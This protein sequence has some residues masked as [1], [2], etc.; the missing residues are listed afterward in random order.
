[1]NKIG[2]IGVGIMGSRMAPHLLCEDTKLYVYDTVPENCGPLVKAGA[3]AVGSL[4]E[5]AEKADILFSMIPDGKILKAIVGGENGILSANKPGLVLVDMSTVDPGNSEE[6]AAMME[7]KGCFL[8]RSPVS[9]STTFAEEATLKIMVSG[10]KAV[11]ERVRPFL[12]KIG[13]KVTWLGE[14]D[15]ARYIKIAINMMNG[16]TSQMVSEAMILCEAA[17]LDMDVAVDLIADSAA[18]C[19]MIRVKKDMLKSRDYTPRG[20][21]AIHDKDLGIAMQIAAEKKLSL[22]LTGI[23]RGFYGAMVGSGR[24][25]LDYYSLL[26]F[27]EELNG[28]KY[29]PK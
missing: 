9:G 4:R 21:I 7:E 20:T 28:I 25:N 22:P 14:K 12:E 2:W 8:M 3:E 15:E 23:A 18:A 16:I 27:N 24:G 26:L 6:A 13:D 19:P 5:I 17:G 10:D 29:E 11:F 1:M